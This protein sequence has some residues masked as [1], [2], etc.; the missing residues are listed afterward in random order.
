MEG[1][2]EF[3]PFFNPFTVGLSIGLPCGSGFLFCVDIS[4]EML[5]RGKERIFF[6]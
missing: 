2:N 5:Q 3:K 6:L 4:K 1:F